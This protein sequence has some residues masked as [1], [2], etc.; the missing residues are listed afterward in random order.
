MDMLGGHTATWAKG[1]TGFNLVL[2]ST[3]VNWA[4]PGTTFLG[5]KA[6]N[7]DVHMDQPG[8]PR[9]DDCDLDVWGSPYRRT[10]GSKALDLEKLYGPGTVIW[11]CYSRGA[12]IQYRPNSGAGIQYT[13]DTG[14]A[15]VC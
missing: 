7:L 11:T 9:Y 8:E 10:P 5:S 2:P 6:F 14:A 4:D 15:P 12:G 13:L 3:S 1:F